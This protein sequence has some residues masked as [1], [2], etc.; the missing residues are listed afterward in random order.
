MAVVPFVVMNHPCQD[1]DDS[2][3]R[4]LRYVKERDIGALDSLLAEHLDRSYCQ[5][6]RLLGNSSEAEDAV[7]E[8][9]LRLMHTAQRY[10]GSVPFGAWLGWLVHHAALNVRRSRLRRVRRD[11]RASAQ[12]PSSDE[13]EAISSAEEFAAVQ[14]AVLELPDRYRTAIDLHYFAGL[15]QRDI[16]KA[17]GM[18]EDAVAKRMQRAR[19]CLRSLLQRRG[20]AVTGALVVL[21]LNSTPADAAPVSLSAKVMAAAHAASTAS[22]I[23]TSLAI[24]IISTLTAKI[25]AIV[26]MSSLVAGVTWWSLGAATIDRSASTTAPEIQLFA[27]DRAGE[28]KILSVADGSWEWLPNV[29]YELSGCMKTKSGYFNVHLPVDCRDLPVRITYQTCSESAWH[30]TYGGAFYEGA[31]LWAGFSL[32]WDWVAVP[33]AHDYQR[34][35]KRDIYVTDQYICDFSN[36]HMVRLNFMQA[37]TP[38]GRINLST[39]NDT[40]IDNIEI[41]R[42]SADQLPEI[43]RFRDSLNKIPESQRHGTV[44]APGLTADDSGRELMII[45]LETNGE[46]IPNKR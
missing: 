5:A 34:W 6:K 29:G 45:F 22:A 3:R 17:L 11:K 42:I 12:R 26:G 7:Q 44:A 4:F 41:R 1:A 24:P 35:V 27:F 31:R 8:A 28:E 9:I 33:P 23:S 18:H 13:Q 25:L 43:D 14:K 15:S 37:T 10:D 30:P 20:V 38:T 36:G 39:L 21:A 19:E 2:S 40:R 46:F 32:A 16:G